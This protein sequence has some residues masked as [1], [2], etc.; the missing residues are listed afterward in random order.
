[1]HIDY[2]LSYRCKEHDGPVTFIQN[3]CHHL[4][5]H[6][7]LI[8]IDIL[9]VPLRRNNVQQTKAFSRYVANR[10][11]GIVTFV[12]AVIEDCCNI[13]GYSILNGEF[14]VGTIINL[15]LTHIENASNLLGRCLPMSAVIRSIFLSSMILIRI[16][17]RKL[18]LVP[19]GNECFNVSIHSRQTK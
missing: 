2:V 19:N 8:F 4:N 16:V 6:L 3:L 9:F 14:Y 5:T 13:S 1:M 17:R 11:S 10:W 12:N 15:Q 18:V 7:N